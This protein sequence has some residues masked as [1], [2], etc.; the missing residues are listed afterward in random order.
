MRL[1]RSLITFSIAWTW[2]ISGSFCFAA[3]S[4][5]PVTVGYSSF[6]G[7]YL[8][9]WIAIEER[10]GRKY[11]LDLKA[12]YAGRVRPRRLLASNVERVSC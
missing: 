9:L 10:L 11:G 12:I 5:E 7:A 2:L 6:S 8:P 4:L 1:I 3:A